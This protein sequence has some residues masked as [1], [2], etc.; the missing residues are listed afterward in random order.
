MAFADSTVPTKAGAWCM[1]KLLES[2]V[3]RVERNEPKLNTNVARRG[4]AL[5]SL[6]HF[7]R[8]SRVPCVVVNPEVDGELPLASKKSDRTGTRQPDDAE[9]SVLCSYEL[10]TEKTPC[11]MCLLSDERLLKKVRRYSLFLYV[12][13]MI[14]AIA[15]RLAP[16]SRPAVV[17]SLPAGYGLPV[18]CASFT[19][20]TLVVQELLARVL[21]RGPAPAP[22]LTPEAAWPLGIST[23]MFVTMFFHSYLCFG[24]DGYFVRSCDEW[25]A[26]C[27]ASSLNLF[28]ATLTVSISLRALLACHEFFDSFVSLELGRLRF[29]VRVLHA[30]RH[31][32]LAFLAGLLGLRRTLQFAETYK[33]LQK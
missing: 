6:S 24:G 10:I 8:V 27:V 25:A 4:G 3:H 22:R 29:C 12:G 21:E 26:A 16:A 17:P 32:R 19:V 28:I 7:C 31:A 15:P 30:D 18:T 2:Q 13:S 20:A 1:T 9:K 5:V 33:S 14:V 23:W 11:A